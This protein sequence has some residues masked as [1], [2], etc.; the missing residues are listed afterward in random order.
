MVR[1]LT[2]PTCLQTKSLRLLIPCTALF[3]QGPPEQY[4]IDEDT[5]MLHAGLENTSG[6]Y[7][8]TKITEIQFWFDQSDYWDQLI[9]NYDD[10]IDIPA[11]VI[12]EDDTLEQAG[13]R[14]KGNTSYMGTNSLRY[15]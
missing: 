13:I 4:W 1:A 9:D 8:N 12:I 14:F 11:T 7:D 15:I 2:L 10:A 3:S 5:H 6:L